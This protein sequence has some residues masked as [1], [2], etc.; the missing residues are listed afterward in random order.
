MPRNNE[1]DHDWNFKAV[2]IKSYVPII[3]IQCMTQLSI[4]KHLLFAPLVL[5]LLSIFSEWVAFG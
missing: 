5:L 3:L 1:I 4:T 2:A